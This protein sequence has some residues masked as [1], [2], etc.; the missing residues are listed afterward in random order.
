MCVRLLEVRINAFFFH[1]QASCLSS[2]PKTPLPPS[3][4]SSKS[5]L[6]WCFNWPP[7]IETSA[8]ELSF[9]FSIKWPHRHLWQP[10]KF[11]YYSL[12]FHYWASL[13][14]QMV[15]NPPAMWETWVWSLGW[16][17]ALEEGMATHSSILAWRIPW[18][19]EP[20][21]PQSRGSQRVGQDW[22]HSTHV[23]TN[24]L[25]LVASI[26]LVPILPDLNFSL[27]S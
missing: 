22:A 19:E 5:Q 1:A 8:S 21:G 23:I 25:H 26:K 18:T 16:E 9:F 14:A 24:T 17:G 27:N 12:S 10:G 3:M 15:K 7:S 13:V 2:Q 20:G 6:Q 11:R 4:I